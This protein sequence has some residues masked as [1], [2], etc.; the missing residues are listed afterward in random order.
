[1]ALADI[2]NGS[3][4]DGLLSGLEEVTLEDG[5]LVVRTLTVITQTLDPKEAIVDQ[6]KNLRDKKAL[7]QG[8]IDR[9]VALK[10][11]YDALKG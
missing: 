10:A 3:P 5:Q 4:L 11:Q 6:L 7:I 2:T 8:R 1:M 9:L